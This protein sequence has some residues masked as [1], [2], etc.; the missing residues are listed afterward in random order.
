MHLGT[1]GQG[2]NALSGPE[3]PPRPGTEPAT[4]THAHP[5]FVPGFVKVGSDTRLV[6]TQGPVPAR[7]SRSVGASQLP[8]TFTSADTHVKPT[9]LTPEVGV[10]R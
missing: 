9:V 1:C 7:P 2:P 4:P 5:K 10:A 3:E 6:A 8:P